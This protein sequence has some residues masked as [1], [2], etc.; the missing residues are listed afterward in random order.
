MMRD[1]LTH[2]RSEL[3]GQRPRTLKAAWAVFRK[4][5]RSELRTRYA[6]NAVALFAVSTVVALSLGMGPLLPSR[7]DDLGIIQA[8]LLWVALLFAA[9]TGLARS[10]VQEEEARTA[11]ALRLSAAPIAVY[12]GKLL[13]N[14]AL[15]LALG[16]L[17]ALLF[18]ILLRVRVGNPALF[19]GLIGAGC[20]GLVAATTLIAAI[21]SR[22]NVK[23]ALFAVL[24][25]PLL[26]PLLVVAVQGTALAIE[27]AG[28][29]QGLAPLQVLLAYAVALFVA[30]LFLFQA[31]WEA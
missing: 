6:L 5:V 4:D 8:A 3:A 24:S 26:V 14:L 18:V 20:L 16:V 1:A 7:N 11:A 19:A 2:D 17:I 27:G 30:S 25:F 13:F 22:A 9:F 29:A 15:L 10:F 21:I 31:V 28:W 12:L 23:G